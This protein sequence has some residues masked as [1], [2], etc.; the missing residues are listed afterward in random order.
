MKVSAQKRVSKLDVSKQISGQISGQSLGQNALGSGIEDASLCSLAVALWGWQTGLLFVAVPIIAILE[1]RRFVQQRWEISLSDLK[2]AA[3]LSGAILAILFVVLVT[4]EKSVFIY[5]LFQWLPVAALPLLLAQTYGLGVQALLADW[6]ANPY[7]PRQDRS[8]QAGSRRDPRSKQSPITLHHVFFGLCLMAASATKSDHFF[9]YG[10]ASALIAVFLW[11]RRPKR[12]TP[13]LWLLLFLLSTGLGFAGHLQIARFQRQIE[14]Q[15]LAMIGTMSSGIVDPDSSATQMGSVGRLKLS[16]A[17]AFRVAPTEALS[18]PASDSSSSDSSAARASVVNAADPSMFPLLLQQASY[19]QYQLSTWRAEN[20]LFED[21]PPGEE[22]GEWVLSAS[23]E[24]DRSIVFSADLE[25]GDGV[26][27]L[28]RGTS[29]IRHLPV[30]EMQHNQYGVVQVDATGTVDYEIQF[31]PSEGINL[32]ETRP[33]RTDLQVPNADRAAIET[34]LAKLDIAGKSEREKASRIAAYF[35]DFQYTLDLLRPS[36]DT[37]PVS[38]FLLNTQAGHC[39]YFASATALL[40]RG[41]GIPARYAVGFLAHEFSP[42]EGRYLVRSRDAHAWAL[43]YIEGEWQVLDTTPPD[44]PAQEEAMT[45]SFQSVSDFFSFLGFQAFYRIRQLGELG[46]REILM[47]VI[48]LFCYLLWRSIQAFQGQRQRAID[49]DEA[50]LRPVQS[51]LDSEFYQIEQML[52]ERG[53]SRR[54]VESLLQWRDRI[55]LSLPAS[56]Q[57]TFTEILGLHYRYRFDPCSLDPTERQRLKNLSQQWMTFYL[58]N[59]QIQAGA[60]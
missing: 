27:S 1:A 57:A 37:A 17:I 45:S 23:G 38:D 42:L 56:Q 9:F 43:A 5:S 15:V 59:E 21:V 60:D 34:T 16:N 4:V 24:Q 33:N 39:E 47:I 8:R 58:A 12:S 29:A 48:P 3:K 55:Y 26:L 25:W 49:V 7:L 36:P 50:G 51:G 2:E 31:G 46:L 6:F 20:S 22:D 19:N 44:W 28:P 11:S 52:D 10:A 40:L 54:P 32:S 35:Q 13:I 30:E 14:A 53:W 41:A 18:R